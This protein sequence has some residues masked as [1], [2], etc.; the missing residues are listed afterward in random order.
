M[1]KEDSKHV[2]S[3]HSK[4]TTSLWD[5]LEKIRTKVH[6]TTYH[7]WYFHNVKLHNRKLDPCSRQG[8]FLKPETTRLSFVEWSSRRLV[9]LETLQFSIHHLQ[10]SQWTSTCFAKKIFKLWFRF[11]LWL[12]S[13]RT[14][15]NG[16]QLFSGS[17]VLHYPS[18]PS[19][20]AA[21]ID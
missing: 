8:F 18:I 17:T 10:T 13:S 15:P 14:V 11:S 12:V 3:N 16:P 20:G 21:N 2:R 19:L 7:K 4:I 5:S 1:W 9:N 6:A